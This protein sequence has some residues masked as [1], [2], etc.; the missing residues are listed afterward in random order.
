MNLKKHIQIENE[1]IH[2]L[3]S[4]RS[5]NDIEKLAKKLELN[6]NFNLTSSSIKLRGVWE[7][8]WSSSKAPFLNYSP[9]LDNL[10]I[11]D[12]IKLN[13]MNLIKPIGI[14]SI[15]GT[16]ILVKLEPL[17]EKRI[18]VK[19]THAG[20]IGPTLGSKKIKALKKIEKEQTGWL[21]ITYL[22]YK[23]RICRGDKG[24]LFILMKR[25]DEILFNKFKEFMNIFSK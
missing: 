14:E 19:F 17:G 16:G 5:S 10:Q 24:T 15:L 3:L 1:L 9:I 21:D 13:G 23:V 7:L 18:G 8:R 11:L 22:S 4:D 12:P 6:S 2:L 20:L 25:N